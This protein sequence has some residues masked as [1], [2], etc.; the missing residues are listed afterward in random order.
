MKVRQA[1]RYVFADPLHPPFALCSE[2]GTISLRDISA[3]GLRYHGQRAEQLLLC[4]SDAVA[5]DLLSSDVPQAGK[6]L[7]V[8]SV[9]PRNAD[10]VLRFEEC[11]EWMD[12][13]LVGLTATGRLRSESRYDAL[14]SEVFSTFEQTIDRCPELRRQHVLEWF[15]ANLPN[16]GPVEGARYRA[17]LFVVE[18]ALGQYYFSRSEF[19]DHLRS[20]ASRIDKADDWSCVHWVPMRMPSRLAMIL[21]SCVDKQPKRHQWMPCLHEFLLRES[22]QS[23]D[24]G[25]NACLVALDSFMN[26]GITRDR[27]LRLLARFPEVARKYRVVYLAAVA[28]YAPDGSAEWVW[29]GG[30]LDPSPEFR[31]IIGR[32]LGEPDR[33]PHCVR[34]RGDLLVRGELQDFVDAS[35][36]PD[37]GRPTLVSFYYACP[38]AVLPILWAER[39]G[40][41]PLLKPLEY[42]SPSYRPLARAPFFAAYQQTFDQLRRRIVRGGVVLLYAPMGSGKSYLAARAMEFSRPSFYIVWHDCLEFDGIETLLERLDSFL[43]QLGIA[44]PSLLRSWRQP[45]NEEEL[46]TELL[47]RLSVLDQP[48][49]I[50]LDK[51]QNVSPFHR[52]PPEEPDSTPLWLFITHLVESFRRAS[53]EDTAAAARSTLILIT[54]TTESS[55]NPDGSVVSGLDP[56]A[57]PVI[58]RLCEQLDITSEERLYCPADGNDSFDAALLA[59]RLVTN[60]SVEK[61]FEETIT[62]LSYLEPYKTWLLCFWVNRCVRRAG[63]DD[64]AAVNRYVA[65]LLDK[66]YGTQFAKVDRIHQLLDRQLAPEERRLLQ[67][68]SAFLLPWSVAEISAVFVDS[69]CASD[70]DSAASRDRVELM[71]REFLED[72][73]PYLV[74]LGVSLQDG[75]SRAD[76]PYSDRLEFDATRVEA[77]ERFE[78]PS[79]TAQYYRKNLQASTDRTVVYQSLARL[80]EARLKQEHDE[81]RKVSFW[82]LVLMYYCEAGR[83]SNAARLYA[84]GPAY[85]ALRR[86]NSWDR[87]VQLGKAIFKAAGPG[88]SDFAGDLWYGTAVIYANAVVEVMRADEAYH[89]CTETLRR[90]PTSDQYWKARLRLIQGKCRRYEGRYDD[91]IEAYQQVLELLGRIRGRRKQE[92]VLWRARTLA[93][94]SQCFMSLGRLRDAEISLTAARHL[95]DTAQNLESPLQSHRATLAGLIRRHEGT[96]LLLSGELTKAREQYE[97]LL[98]SLEFDQ[99]RAVILFKLARARIE[100]A[101]EREAL[102]GRASSSLPDHKSGELTEAGN[103]LEQSYS[104]LTEA[105]N[106]LSR[107]NSSDRKWYTA[108]HLAK[109]DREIL[110]RRRA[111]WVGLP[112]PENV[113]D[114]TDTIRTVTGRLSRIDPKSQSALRL[115]IDLL[116]CSCQYQVDLESLEAGNGDA[117]I[118]FDRLRDVLRSLIERD[119]ADSGYRLKACPYQR[120]RGYYEIAYYLWRLQWWLVK[121]PTTFRLEEEVSS[122]MASAYRCGV[123]IL[124]AHQLFRLAVPFHRLMLDGLRHSPSRKLRL[125]ECLEAAL[126]RE[127]SASIQSL[128]DEIAENAS[129]HARVELDEYFIIPAKVLSRL[130]GDDHLYVGLEKHGFPDKGVV[131]SVVE[132]MRRVVDLLRIEVVQWCVRAIE[133][134]DQYWNGFIGTHEVPLDW[135]QGVELLTSRMQAL[136]SF[137]KDTQVIVVAEPSPREDGS[138]AGRSTE[139]RRRRRASNRD[140]LRTPQ[141]RRERNPV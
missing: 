42:Y 132:P 134:R 121:H 96:L 111:S 39:D 21:G 58:E 67:V 112:L 1:R 64:A 28:G 84:G 60:A 10:W 119:R 63:T 78:M 2:H 17:A 48:V 95:V 117:R 82:I 118:F 32:A 27:F 133:R 115:D 15:L 36:M 6:P 128:L 124:Y 107:S 65:S 80:M 38:F 79:V 30:E 114:L 55:T 105:E 45:W 135:P 101:R 120:S 16:L 12:N 130:K 57:D 99:P 7:K 20:L 102:G 14:G 131:V 54:H 137:L 19:S 139:R 69:F 123:N 37:R 43:T 53:A 13:L 75:H 127:E 77:G 61:E 74:P 100:T 26:R 125:Q 138:Y 103:A 94:Q 31:T 136:L 56:F 11:Y 81:A 4:P 49:L 97:G 113:R 70:V 89:L 25:P 3:S 72:R 76:R 29:P 40:W 51:V 47:R 24:V 68:A 18:A 90:A 140:R 22:R 52:D 108:I 46:A 88:D 86:R 104:E 93:A 85:D 92:A 71:V 66:Q 33:P 34:D 110:S 83:A 98:Q 109:V 8:A 122:E 91:A 106:A 9:W 126:W 44:S 35:D 129:K 62:R 41:T 87:I 141:P 5:H 59:R 50:V 23:E 116:T 73:A